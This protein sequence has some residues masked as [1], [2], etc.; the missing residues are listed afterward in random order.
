M[1]LSPPPV[2]LDTK[3]LS[4]ALSVSRRTIARWVENGV[5]VVDISRGTKRRSLRFDVPAVLE[6]LSLQKPEKPEK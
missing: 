5:P 1:T 3:G 2:L 4:Q 6:W